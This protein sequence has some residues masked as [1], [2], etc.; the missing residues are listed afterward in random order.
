MQGLESTITINADFDYGEGGINFHWVDSLGYSASL[1]IDLDGWCTREMPIRS[2]QG[3]PKLELLERNRIR[4]RFSSSLAKK[5]ELDERVEF[6]FQADDQT[7]EQLK[8]FQEL[9]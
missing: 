8:G 5:L 4:L 9:W 7:F 2:G 6:T 1:D 3:P